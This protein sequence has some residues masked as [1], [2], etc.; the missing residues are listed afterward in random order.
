MIALD[1]DTF[2]YAKNLFANFPPY[3]RCYLGAVFERHQAGKIFVDRQD[4]PTC[5][6]LFHTGGHTLLA[7]DPACESIAA[8]LDQLSPTTA[9]GKKALIFVGEHRGWEDKIE[10]IYEDRV[11]KEP[12]IA[13]QLNR[14]LF[15]AGEPETAAPGSVERIGEDTLTLLPDLLNPLKNRNWDS[16]EEFFRCGMGFCLIVDGRAVSVCSSVALGEGT[17]PIQIT[18]L[19]DCTRRGFATRVAHTYIDHCLKADLEPYWECGVDNAASASTA[20]KVGFR[21]FGKLNRYWLVE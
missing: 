8:F 7:G 17:A 10:Q 14:D 15:T 12:R 18:T 19:P 13:F 3:K 21:P 1:T 6:C 20:E 11:R 5:A 2:H 16:K 9:I 4:K